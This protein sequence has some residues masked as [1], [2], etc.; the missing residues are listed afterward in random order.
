[1]RQPRNVL[2]SWITAI[3]MDGKGVTKWEA[4]FTASLAEQLGER[5]TLSEKQ[6]EILERIYA[7]RT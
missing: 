1:M 3:L 7:E 5:G 4:D 6:V 2:E